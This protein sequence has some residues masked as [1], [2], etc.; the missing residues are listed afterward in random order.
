MSNPFD[1][2]RL[3]R[4]L[5]E[6]EDFK[7]TVEDMSHGEC[8]PFADDELRSAKALVQVSYDLISLVAEEHGVDFDDLDS[9]DHIEEALDDI[10]ESASEAE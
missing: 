8:V 2:E 7:N 5:S 4:L 10:N 1:F 9:N 6:L 3:N